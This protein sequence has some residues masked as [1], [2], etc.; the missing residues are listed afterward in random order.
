MKIANLQ[1]M[2]GWKIKALD[3]SIEDISEIF[4]E[5]DMGWGAVVSKG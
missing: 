2:G 1:K 4:S 5:N 3:D